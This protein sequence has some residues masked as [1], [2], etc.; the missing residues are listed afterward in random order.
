MGFRVVLEAGLRRGQRTGTCQLCG[1]AERFRAELMLAGGASAKAVGE[2]FDLSHHAVWRH[3]TNHVATERKA[4]L[5]A[6]PLKLSQL[7]ERAAEEGLSLIDYLRL[8][9]STL[10]SQFTS[11]AEAGD[12]HGTALLAGRLLEALREIGRLTGE[13]GRLGGGVNVTNNIAILA[14]P[15]FAELQ[16][17]LL[18]RLAPFPDARASVLTGLR[19]LDQR[20]GGGVPSAPLMIEGAAA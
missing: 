16:Q 15:A 17:M 5:I 19:E 13:L 20:L 11:C 14:S 12:N 18:E 6:G 2:K 10:L 8:V 9:R 4:Q 7:A 3:W 1:H